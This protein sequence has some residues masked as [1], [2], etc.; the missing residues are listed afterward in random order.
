MT[1]FITVISRSPNQV[2]AYFYNGTE[3]EMRGEVE[4][5]TSRGEWFILT[6]PDEAGGE[7]QAGRLNSGMHVSKVHESL[8]AAQQFLLDVFGV[9]S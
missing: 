4:D 7:Y 1:V 6:A 5:G 9:Q 2:P 8:E 3:I